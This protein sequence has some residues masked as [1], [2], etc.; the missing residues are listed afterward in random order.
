MD[1]RYRSSR[2]DPSTGSFCHLY[3][4]SWR[5]RRMRLVL[6]GTVVNT[7]YGKN[8]EGDTIAVFTEHV[9]NGSFFR[10]DKNQI[11]RMSNPNG[12][13]AVSFH[14]YSPPLEGA[15]TYEEAVA[16]SGSGAVPVMAD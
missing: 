4:R 1:I 15:R 10:A 8:P 12:E 16:A 14:V 9:P 6:E 5:I 2:S 13:R 7:V 11:H 3:S